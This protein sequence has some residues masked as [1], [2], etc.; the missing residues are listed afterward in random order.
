[1][2]IMRWD[3]WGDIAALQRDM[4]RLARAATSSALGPSETAGIVPAIDAWRTDEGMVVHAELAGFGPDEVEVNVQDG[5]LTISGER[6]L[7][8]DVTDEQW[9]RRER[10]YGRFDR[11]F[12]LPEG[13]DADAIKASFTNGVLELTIPHPPEKQPRRIPVGGGDREAI[14]VSTSR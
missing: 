7:R 5:I 2:A 12:T 1:M 4:D 14:D 9:V 6:K 8:T 3:P 10:R 11:S 13:T